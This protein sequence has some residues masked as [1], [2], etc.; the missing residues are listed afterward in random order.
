MTFKKEEDSVLRYQ[1]KLSVQM[2]DG[3][4]GRIMEEGH[5]SK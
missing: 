5:R 3:I 1:D 4:Q 2:E